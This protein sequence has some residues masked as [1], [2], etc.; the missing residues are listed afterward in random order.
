MMTRHW[1]QIEMTGQLHTLRV[2]IPVL[3]GKKTGGPQSRYE[4]GCEDYNS[5]ELVT[6]QKLENSH[7][8]ASV[9][10]FLLI[11]IIKD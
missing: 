5:A 2:L 10:N 8:I 1:H 9:S 7:F 6:S 3:T 11:G 4:L